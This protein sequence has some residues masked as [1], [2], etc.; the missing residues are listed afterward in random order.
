MS[1]GFAKIMKKLSKKLNYTVNR[2]LDKPRKTAEIVY[3]GGYSQ[4]INMRKSTELLH[5]RAKQD[6]IFKIK[7]FYIYIAFYQ[8]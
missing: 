4:K 7:C 1:I 6:T 5:L 3:G 2:L 8:S